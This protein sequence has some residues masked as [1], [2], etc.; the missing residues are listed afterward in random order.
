MDAVYS[1]IPA[2]LVGREQEIEVGPMSGKSNVMFWLEQHGI[3]CSDPVVDRVFAQGEVV[4]D[5]A[6]RSRDSRPKC[7]AEPLIRATR[8]QFL[9][10]RAS[11][12]GSAAST[13]SPTICR[14]RAPTLSS[15]SLAVCHGG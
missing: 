15:V 9:S 5:G 8:A 11:I 6:D 10:S 7:T 12:S 2:S 3:P 4:D 1:A 13:T 14:L